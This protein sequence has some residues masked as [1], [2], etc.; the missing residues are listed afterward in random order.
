M[1][2]IVV[3]LAFLLLQIAF[4]KT[5]NPTNVFEKIDSETQACLDT[6]MGM[7]NCEYGAIDKYEIEIEKL[8]K[9]FKKVFSQSQYDELIKTQ[10]LWDGFYK[11][12]NALLNNTLGDTDATLIHLISVGQSLNAIKNRA[13]E[14]NKLYELYSSFK[15]D[16]YYD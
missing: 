4:A 5:Q 10:K 16:G 8:L 6:G 13:I 2:K 3:I 1:K 9:K 11:Q 7:T 14:L 12:N 15:K